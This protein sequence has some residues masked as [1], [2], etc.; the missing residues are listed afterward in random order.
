MLKV[1]CKW[2]RINPNADLIVA[3]GECAIITKVFS[4][5]VTYIAE[6]N[7]HIGEGTLGKSMFLE[8][9]VPTSTN[10]DIIQE[11]CNESG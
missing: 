3:F 8:F 9:Y 4:D 7:R 6:N 2:K 5:R 1:G 10:K 11:L